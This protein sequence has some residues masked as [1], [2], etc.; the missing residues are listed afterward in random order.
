MFC[1]EVALER[2]LDAASGGGADFA[3]VYCEDNRMTLIDA[4]AKGIDS[5]SA[6][7]ESG[8]GIRIFSGLRCYYAY[9]NDCRESTLLRLTRD[10]TEVCR[11]R[12][13][14]RMPLQATMDFASESTRMTACPADDAERL[15]QVRRV[16]AAGEGLHSEICQMNVHYLDTDR[17]F[18]VAN[19]EGLL[20]GDRQI[21]TRMRINAYAQYG[22]NLQRGYRG[23]GA[24]GGA[25]FY[26]QIDLEDIVSQA[27]AA[28]RMAAHAQKC[29]G[30][31]MPVVLNSGFCGLMFH[32]ACGHSLE[33]NSVSKGNS[34]FSGKLG[35]RVASPLVTLVDDG[36]LAGQ[37]GSL[38]M[39]DEGIPAQR[40]VLIENGILKGYM[41]DRLESR[42]MGMAPTGSGRRQNY[43]FSPEARMTNTFIAPGDSGKEEIIAATERGLFVG[44]IN[45]GSVN[46]ATGDFNFSACECWLIEEGRLTQP[47]YG[48]TLIGK[49]GE[50]LLDV[51]MV[52]NDLE[53]GQ[54]YCYNN[55]GA[56]FIGAGQPTLRVRKMLVGGL[57]SC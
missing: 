29:P 26:D 5:C 4:G 52:G 33:A 14:Q 22:E 8:I 38:H 23:P 12:A 16:L 11:T 2:V 50:V 20:A 46:P 49:G 35:R 57:V 27:A 39:D 41:I 10:L 18:L 21:K 9:T 15:R 42:R 45:G 36:T 19:S 47:V 56:L 7:R 54:G 34:E 25:E 31:S 28:A 24:M 51:D 40:N 1:T 30:G 17:Q 3:E 43:R 37:W 32:E 48:A 44:N 53:I 55:S 6:G 13:K